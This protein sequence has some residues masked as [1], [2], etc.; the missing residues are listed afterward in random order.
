VT[1]SNPGMILLFFI[2]RTLEIKFVN[3]LYYFDLLIAELILGVKDIHS[4]YSVYQYSTDMRD[5]CSSSISPDFALP[6]YVFWRPFNGMGK[7]R[8]VR[9]R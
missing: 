3:V 4:G 1:S 8:P 7:M 6:R 9:S 2:F 5:T